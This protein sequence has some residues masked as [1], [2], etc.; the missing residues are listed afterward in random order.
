[1]PAVEWFAHTFPNRW[2]DRTV[3]EAICSFEPGEAYQRSQLQEYVQGVLRENGLVD[4]GETFPAGPLPE[5]GRDG[6]VSLLMQTALWFQARA[7]HPVS[8]F[9][10]FPRANPGK[11][12]GLVEHHHGDVGLTAVKLAVEV[13][14]GKRRELAGPFAAFSKFARERRAP[15]DTRALL[16]AARRCDIPTLMLERL[17]YKREDFNDLTG[18]QCLRRNGLVMLGHGRYRHVLDGLFCLDK[19]AQYDHLRTGRGPRLQ[20]LERLGLAGGGL[21]GG[22]KERQRYLIVV[23]NGQISA[24]IERAGGR[25]MKPECV[26]ADLADEV[27]KINCEVGFAPM[28]VQVEST[29]AA[30]PLALADSKVVDFELAP[31]LDIH[32][33]TT[34]AQAQRLMASTADLVVDWLF[35]DRGQARIPIVAITGTNGKTTTTRLINHIFRSAGQTPG[36][37]C[38]DGV[39]VGGEEIRKCDHGSVSGHLQVLTHQQPDIAVLETHHAGILTN[40]F[41]F[42]WCDVAVCLNVTEDHLGQV[43]VESVSE[44]ATVKQALVER[45][46]HAVVLN[47]DDAHCRGMIK[48][49]KAE[50]TCLV[51]M[52]KTADELLRGFDT[53]RTSVAVLE[54]VSGEPWI[55]MYHRRERHPLMA[56]SNIPITFDGAAAFNTGNAMHAALAAFILNAPVEAI[57]S[58]LSTFRPTYDM[59]PGRLNIFDDLPFRVIMDFAHNPD[60]HVKLSRFIATR[61]VTGRKILAFSATINRADETILNMGRAVAG[62]YDF[63]F[64]KEYFPSIR[65]LSRT[66]AHLLQ[67]GLMESGVA[68]EQTAV[69]GHGKEVIFEILDFCRPGDLLVILMGHK[70]K[71]RLPVYIREYAEKTA[72]RKS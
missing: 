59:I 71:H 12:T 28:T 6:Y 4:E 37:V 48:S 7:G 41:A 32:L 40:G 31:D 63:Y 49:S 2:S 64:C 33:Q 17:P 62:C 25:W 43:H 55:V 22:A 50:L 27:L 45:G 44:M 30:P 38:T 35:H 20:L 16:E 51:S 70:E 8:Y 23:A 29:A 56:V 13:L 11:R 58:A 66:V 3:V 72:G 34:D 15:E 14:G 42:D 69:R 57:R 19:S 18:G 5:D 24:L 10:V 9:A 52:E 47:A 61:Q 68:E 26:G 1:M 39:Y 60:G 65:N 54:T 53:Q 36:M 46:R 67:Q 21:Q